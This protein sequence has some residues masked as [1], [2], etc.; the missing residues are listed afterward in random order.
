MDLLDT[1]LSDPS[2]FSCALFKGLGLDD[3]RVNSYP[4]NI[5]ETEPY[6]VNEPYLSSCCRFIIL[7]MSMPPVSGC[8]Q[9][10]DLDMKFDFGPYDG[11]GP[12]MSV[13][14]DLKLWRYLRFKKDL[15]PKL[16]RWFLLLHQ[17]DVEIVDKG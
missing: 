9:E 7:W 15:N 6:V 5:V 8:V 16:L 3:D 2:S 12:K 10:L 13:L 14:L 17:F 1:N 11:D 4:P